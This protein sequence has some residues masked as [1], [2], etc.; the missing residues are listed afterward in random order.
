MQYVTKEHTDKVEERQ[1]CNLVL[2]GAVLPF[3]L[4]RFAG[5]VP[6]CLLHPALCE[7]LVNKLHAKAMDI[8]DQQRYAITR[9]ARGGNLSLVACAPSSCHRNSCRLFTE[10]RQSRRMRE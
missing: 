9:E 8:L 3:C 4:L 7:E 6:F 1:P 2:P 10:K 5:S